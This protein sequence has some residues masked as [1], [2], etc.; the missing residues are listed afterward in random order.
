VGGSTG[1][2]DDHSTEYLNGFA[3]HAGFKSTAGNLLRGS[4]YTYAATVD[5]ATGGGGNFYLRSSFF[6]GVGGNTENSLDESH[7]LA[8]VGQTLTLD[9]G[10][11]FVITSD[12]K[13]T[14]AGQLVFGPSPPGPPPSSG[15]IDQIGLM[16]SFNS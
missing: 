16:T 2:F 8:L 7:A 9:G 4:I 1:N 13:D 5:F 6:T 14:L 11:N 15:D 10:T 3:F 12:Y